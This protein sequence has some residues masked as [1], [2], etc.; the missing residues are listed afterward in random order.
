MNVRMTKYDSFD[1]SGP[2]L[3]EKNTE[4]HESNGNKYT[5][6]AQNVFSAKF[7]FSLCYYLYFWKEKKILYN[8]SE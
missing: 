3:L 4:T 5:K 2:G 8:T 6:Y 1:I 7:A